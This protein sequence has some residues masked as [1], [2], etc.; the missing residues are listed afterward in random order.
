MEKQQ[1]TEKSQKYGKR[2]LWIEIRVTHMNTLHTPT[3]THKHTRT[4]AWWKTILHE[5]HVFLL[6]FQ[7]NL[8]KGFFPYS[9]PRMFLQH[10]VWVDEHSASLTP[11]ETRADLLPYQSSKVSVQGSLGRFASNSLLIVGVSSGHISSVM[12]QNHVDSIHMDPSP[13]YPVEFG[14]NRKRWEHEAPDT[15]VPCRVKSSDL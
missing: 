9:V 14:G 6:I 5:S 12:T 8:L 15:C 10:A 4:H 13:N 7:E 1:E 11:S 2:K 3:H